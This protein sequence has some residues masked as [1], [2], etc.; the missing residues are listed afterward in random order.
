MATGLFPKNQIKRISFSETRQNV[1]SQFCL[2]FI[3]CFC[4]KIGLYKTKKFCTFP[5]TVDKPLIQLSLRSNVDY[6]KNVLYF[7]M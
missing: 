1:V 3:I 4:N 6:L 7:I 2:V 5:E